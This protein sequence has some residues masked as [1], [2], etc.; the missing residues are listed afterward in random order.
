MLEKPVSTVTSMD[1]VAVNTMMEVQQG[2]TPYFRNSIKERFVKTIL[3]LSQSSMPGWT[4]QYTDIAWRT[5]W[6]TKIGCPVPFFV[7]LEL[8]RR[9]K[10]EVIEVS[11]VIKKHR[12][13]Y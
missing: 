9:C 12:K 13:T 3:V 11:A 6:P 1:L 10:P 7:L 4:C 8:V 5:V 2:G